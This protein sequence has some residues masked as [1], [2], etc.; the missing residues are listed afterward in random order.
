VTVKSCGRSEENDA[1]AVTVHFGVVV[2]P[3]SSI[4]GVATTAA[5]FQSFGPVM[6]AVKKVRPRCGSKF[7]SGTLIAVDAFAA[8]S[9]SAAEAATPTC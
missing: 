8:N 7:D 2:V 5:V 6:A 4:Q 1:G 3:G 9:G